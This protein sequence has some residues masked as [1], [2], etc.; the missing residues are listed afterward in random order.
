MNRVEPARA[1]RG[2]DDLWL[3]TTY[4]NPR[5]YETRRRNQRAFA[6][7]FAASSLRLLTVECA[8]RNDAFVLP[9]SPDVLRVRARDLMWQKE[10]LLNLIIA[11]LPASC[12]KVAWLDCDVLFENSAWAVETSRLLD[13]YPIVQPFDTAVRLPRGTTVDEGRS[14]A[15]QGFGAVHGLAPHAVRSGRDEAHG[16]TGLAWA[17]RR[18]V[19]ARCGLYDACVIGGADHAMAHAMCGDF[20][21]GCVQLLLDNRNRH[22]RHF[23]GWGARFCDEVRGRIGFVPGAALH[24]WHGPHADRAYSRRHRLL[25]EYGFDPDTDLRIGRDGCWEWATDKP[26]MHRSVAE[27]FTQRNEDGVLHPSE[28][29]ALQGLTPPRD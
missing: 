20:D 14:H 23:V 25:E 11:R 28:R 13:E 12:T 4:F 18:E 8:F 2:V 16:E 3:V 19:L 7:A 17:A 5:N 21:S 6:A 26:E 1:Y 22:W 24:L 10:R 15:R 9:D 27:Y 29:P